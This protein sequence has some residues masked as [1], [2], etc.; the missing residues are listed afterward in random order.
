MVD[1]L[2]R[3]CTSGCCYNCCRC[4]LKNDVCGWLCLLLLLR[5]RQ[6]AVAVDSFVI[7]YVE[8][9]AMVDDVEVD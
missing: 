7:S 1:R 3:F 6:R 2:D 4:S 8:I 9:V 5:R